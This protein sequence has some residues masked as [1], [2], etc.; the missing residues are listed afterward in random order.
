[1][2]AL[3]NEPCFAC[4]KTGRL[5]QITPEQAQRFL[6]ARTP[7]HPPPG[8]INVHCG[9]CQSTYSTAAPTEGEGKS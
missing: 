1:M 8:S 4:G 5:R 6:G 9:S 3:K 2:T 7:Q